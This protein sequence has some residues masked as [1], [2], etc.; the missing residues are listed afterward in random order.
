M[1]LKVAST[2]TI[3]VYESEPAADG[4]RQYELWVNGEYAGRPVIYNDTATRE[5]HGRP[6]G[7]ARNYQLGLT[8]YLTPK[9]AIAVYTP[10]A[11]GIHATRAE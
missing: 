2:I 5:T 6:V 7:S 4:V 9:G 1:G 8:A 11:V 3:K 10:E